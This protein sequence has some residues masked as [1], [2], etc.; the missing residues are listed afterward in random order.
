MEALLKDIVGG[1]KLSGTKIT[2]LQE[3]AMKSLKVR[4]IER[5]VV[6]RN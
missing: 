6:A 3:M 2:K 4:N 1:K 5:L